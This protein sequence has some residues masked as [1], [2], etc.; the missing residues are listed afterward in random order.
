MNRQL[1]IVALAGLVIGLIAMALTQ[2]PRSGR[3]NAL[4]DPASVERELLADQ[5]GGALSLAIKRTFPEDFEALKQAVVDRAR[6]GGTPQ[7]I[8]QVAGAFVSEATRNRRASLVQAPVADL[9]GYL[10]AEIA[11]VEQLAA[12]SPERCAAYFADP[13]NDAGW[14]APDLRDLYLR[15]NIALWQAAA[16]ARDHPAGRTLASPS[17][18]PVSCTEGLDARKK[19]AAL[20]DAQFGQVYPAML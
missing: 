6:A 7:E 13:L 15:Q 4:T 19:A 10:A 12:T 2:W 1:R 9:R 18:R 3:Q 11:L 16:G 5:P 20:P 17:P 14:F 8:Q